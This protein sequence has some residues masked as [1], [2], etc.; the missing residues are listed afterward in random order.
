MEP[1]V[2]S[3]GTSYRGRQNEGDVEDRGGEAPHACEV[4]A[5]RDSA[6]GADGERT[7]KGEE[8]EQ[9]QTLLWLAGLDP[10]GGEDCNGDERQERGVNRD[11]DG[12]Q[13]LGHMRPL[14]SR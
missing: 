2:A 1:G 3:E 6:H 4:E 14:R 9:P 12:E 8:P 10:V 11:A 5:V 7:G 13:R